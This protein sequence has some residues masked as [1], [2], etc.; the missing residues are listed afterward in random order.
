MNDND[1]PRLRGNTNTPL[2]GLR[3]EMALS[4]S[5]LFVGMMLLIGLISV[6]GLPFTRDTGLYGEERSQVLETLSLEAD[7]K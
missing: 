1:T 7:L 5:M 2:L 6:F 3:L 4:F